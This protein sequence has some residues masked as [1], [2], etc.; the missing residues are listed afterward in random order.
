MASLSGQFQNY[1]YI[2]RFVAVI[3][4]I[5]KDPHSITS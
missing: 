3:R 5:A 1:E 4:S 2:G